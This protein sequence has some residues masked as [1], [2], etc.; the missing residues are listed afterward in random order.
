M[1][2][3]S[4]C[5]RILPL[6]QFSKNKSRKNGLCEQCKDCNKQ[7]EKEYYSK[8]KEQIDQRHREYRSKNK[9]QIKEYYNRNKKQINQQKKEFRLKFKVEILSHYAN[10]SPKCACCGESHIE[11]L[12]IDHIN[13]NGAEHRRKIGIHS[14]SSFYYWL[15]NN[16]YPSGYR[17]LCHNCNMAFGF[18]GHCP[19]ESDKS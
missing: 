10:G 4:K 14:G 9:K 8:N 13:G 17:V 1:K 7:R 18:D 6:N 5:Q 16:G 11:F 3:C 15:K 12:G 2:R 19:H